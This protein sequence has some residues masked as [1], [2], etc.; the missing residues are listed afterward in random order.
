MELAN[1][2]GTSFAMSNWKFIDYYQYWVDLY[3]RPVVSANT[4]QTYVTSLNH[5]KAYLADVRID[6]LTRNRIQRFLNE[7][8]LSHETARK[9]LM[10]IRSCLR[11]AV[12]DGVIPRNPAEG[13]LQIISNPSLTKGDDQKFMKIAD[14]KKIRDFLL[15]YQYKMTDV[16]RLALLIISQTGLRVGE[17]LALKY[18]DI[19]FLHQ[20]IR[21]DE[22]WDSVHEILKEPKTKHACRT[23]PIPSRV[24]DILE[25]WMKYQRQALFAK[26]ITNSDHFVLW[27][28]DNRLPLSKS[29]NVSYHQLQVKMGMEPKFSTHT[30]RHTLA[31]LM[32]SNP[33]ISLT[34]VSRYL[35]HSNTAITQKYY[36]GLLPEQV[37]I[38][39]KKVIRVIVE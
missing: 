24:L 1:D 19:D 15:N 29:I 3:K 7:L 10:H 33:D 9:D 26:G 37:E 20:T 27:T 14:F 30:L 39:A 8:K 6:E 4:L 5:Y 21:V 2:Q 22:S 18:N 34:Y 16:N 28:R 11:D 12:S 36:I 17:C 31:S 13:R 25:H 38:E 35:G 32:I 23:I